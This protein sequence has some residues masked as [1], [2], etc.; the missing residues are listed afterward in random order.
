MLCPKL[1]CWSLVLS[2]GLSVEKQ[3][4]RLW[5]SRPSG[6]LE[7]CIQSF[8]GKAGMLAW[9]T[10]LRDQL[11]QSVLFFLSFWESLSSHINH[12][13]AYGKFFLIFWSCC[14]SGSRLVCILEPMLT[15]YLS[16]CACRFFLTESSVRIWLGQCCFYGPCCFFV[17]CYSCPLHISST[18]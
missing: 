5:S 16:I 1:S 17:L 13:S 2:T 9:G 14:S 11:G 6:K 18:K 12:L 8:P 15:L 3:T 4:N 7:I 10:T